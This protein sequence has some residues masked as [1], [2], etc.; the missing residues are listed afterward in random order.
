MSG[1]MSDPP[2]TL[3]DAVEEALRLYAP[4][5]AYGQPA[6]LTKYVVVAEYVDATG[7]RNLTAMRAPGMTVWDERGI[8]DT[9]L[10]AWRDA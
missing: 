10:N 4:D 9:R 2:G 1:G 3:H 5:Y 6:V 7:N 8:L